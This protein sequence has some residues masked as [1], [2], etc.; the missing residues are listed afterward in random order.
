M[1]KYAGIGSRETPLDIIQTISSIATTLVKE[2]CILRSGRAPGADTAFEQAHAKIDRTTMELFTEKDATPRLL[3]HAAQ[4]H[5]NWNSCKPFARRL[6]ARNS[7]II[8]GPELDDPVRFV[9]CWTPGG[10]YVGGTAQGMRVAD[11]HKIP[12][13]NLATFPR[14]CYPVL[15]EMIR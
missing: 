13:I 14:S 9:I 1:I 2:G 8:L 5:P 4:Y 3:L 12:I 11:A 7:A 15:M 6:H 10:A